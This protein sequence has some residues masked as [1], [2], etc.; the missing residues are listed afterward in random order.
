MNEIFRI[1]DRI[2]VFRDGEYIMTCGRQ[3]RRRTKSFAPWSAVRSARCSPRKA[4]RTGPPKLAV[5]GFSSLG[6]FRD[7]ALTVHEGEILGL[8]GLPAREE[9]R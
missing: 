4:A 8:A 1:A 3:G 5:S 2:T 6:R 9:P 7:I